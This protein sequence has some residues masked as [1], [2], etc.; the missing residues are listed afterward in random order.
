MT[1]LG[2]GLPQAAHGQVGGIELR[3]APSVPS[4][5]RLSPH[6][7]QGAL[8][9]PDG[10]LDASGARRLV[11]LGDADAGVGG[12]GFCGGGVGGDF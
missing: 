8:D 2:E 5:A 4:M 1:F 9:H 7:S 10:G 3:V 11:E 12:E 6:R